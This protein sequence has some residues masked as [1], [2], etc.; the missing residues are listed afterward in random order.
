MEGNRN[1]NFWFTRYYYESPSQAKYNKQY[2]SPEEEEQRRVI[3]EDNFDRID[4]HN[5]DYEA[6]LVVFELDSNKFADMTQ[7]EFSSLFTGL[8]RD[9]RG[10]DENSTMNIF[11]PSL[12]LEADV[13]D[14]VDWRKK[15]AVTPVKNQ[16][17][18]QKRCL[19]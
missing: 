6:G 17:N 19:L 15:G 16:G 7:D 8:K 4:L 10:A 11:M 13:D 9:S 2:D 5:K 18:L 1:R 3:F 12:L 14:E